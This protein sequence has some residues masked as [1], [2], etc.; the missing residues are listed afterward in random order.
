MS[1]KVSSGETCIKWALKGPLQISC[2]LR[3]G[4]FVQINGQIW[5]REKMGKKF[6]TLFVLRYSCT[7]TCW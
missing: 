4:V 1:V 2:P 6:G 5:L 3:S 7:C